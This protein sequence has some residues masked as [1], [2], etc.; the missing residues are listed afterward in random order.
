MQKLEAYGKM[1]HEIKKAL[2]DSM[3]LD[4]E[5]FNRITSLKRSEAISA[6]VM[7]SKERSEMMIED[8]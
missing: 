8:L 1:I 4:C 7:L 2:G 6:E 3:M 5:I